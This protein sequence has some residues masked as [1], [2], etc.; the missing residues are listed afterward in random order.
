ML[1]Q[2]PDLGLPEMI[3]RVYGHAQVACVMWIICSRWRKAVREEQLARRF[4]PVAGHDLRQQR[5]SARHRQIPKC[6]AWV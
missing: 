3:F 5:T 4:L 2:S 6:T 1:V